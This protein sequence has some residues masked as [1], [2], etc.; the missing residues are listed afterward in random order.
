MKIEIEIDIESIVKEALKKKQE[1][2]PKVWVEA[3][4]NSRSKWEYGR[5][6][7]RRRTTEEMALHDLE[8]Q[9]GRRLTPEEKGEAKALVQI[10]ETAENKAKEDTIKKI[11]IDGITAEGMAAASKE[12]AEETKEQHDIV[13]RVQEGM[14][15]H[16]VNEE[17]AGLNSLIVKE[18][19]EATIPEAKDLKSIDSLFS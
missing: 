10:D 11:R 17:T 2:M 8:K 5:T 4:Q 3:V 12:L 19:P 15:K 16:D 9:K 6:N 13:T 14:D 7:G 18:E 1:E